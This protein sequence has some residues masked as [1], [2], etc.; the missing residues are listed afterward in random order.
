MMDMG[1]ILIVAMVLM[2]VIMCGGMIA[3]GAWALMRRHRGNRDD[4]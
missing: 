3:G 4:Q 1:G 2:M